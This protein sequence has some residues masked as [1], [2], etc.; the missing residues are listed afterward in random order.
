MSDNITLKKL[1]SLIKIQR[2]FRFLKNDIDSK[3]KKI[4]FYKLVLESMINNLIYCNNLKIFQDI[5]S[6]Y[7]AILGELKEI[8]DALDTFPEFL[9]IKY[10]NTEGLSNISLRLIKCELLILKYLNHIAPENLSYILQ[11]IFNENWFN[12]FE[13][14]DLEKIFFISK[15]FIPICLWDSEVHKQEINLNIKNTEPLKKNTMVTKELIETLLGIKKPDNDEKTDVNINSNQ[16]SNIH[17]NIS[18]FLKSIS[19]IIE[20]SPKNSIKK[21]NNHFTL[22]DCNNLLESNKIIIT[23]NPHSNSLI[24]DKY[25]S[26]VYIRIKDRILVLQGIF[27][28]DLLNMSSSIKFVKDKINQ[29]KSVFNYDILT[30]PKIFKD[31]Y[32]STLSLRDIIVLSPS[33]L[34]NDV[35]K[36][37]NDFKMIQD[38]PLITLINEFLLASKYRKIDILTLL[39]M[40]SNDDK[41]VAYILFDIFKSKDKKDFAHEIYQSLHY[42]IR[43]LLDTSKIIVEKEEAKLSKLIDSD[44]PYERR[45][46]MMKTNDEIKAKAME[47]LK[48]IKSSFQGDNKAQLW[49]DGLLKIPFETFKENEILLFKDSFI[50]K[51]K[52]SEPDIQLFSDHEIDIY[53]TDLKTNNSN[54]SLITEWEK[55][56]VDKKNYLINVRKVLDNT[57]F[58]HK[59]AK[60]Q[61]ERI[62][63]QWIN[64][65]SKGAVLGLQG[66]PGTG[67]T[68]LAKNGLSKCLMDKD[69]KSRPFAFLPIG[70]SVNGSTLVG[71]NFTYVGS[72]WGRIVDVLMCAGCM[73]P[74]I[75][76]DEI[77]K[78]SHTD[79]GKEIISILTHMT[80]STQNDEFEDKFFAGIKIDLSK[81]LIVFSFNDPNL[82]DPILRDRI[83]IVETH[84]LS[85]PE[86]LTIIKDYM[87]P[88]ICKDVGFN[89]N[90]LIFSD[91]LIKHLIDTYTNEAGVRKIKEKIIEIVRDINLN[92]FYTN[93]FNMPY[94]ISLDYVKKLFES[95][96]KVRIK[97]II[98][99]PSIGIVN[100]LYASSGGGL[101]GITLIQA[102]KF[103]SDKMLELNLTG[104]AGDVMKESVQYALKNAFRLLTQE[105]QDK[106]INDAQNK[107]TFGIHIHCPD[108]ATPKDGPSAGLAF[109]LAIYSVLSGRKIKN[110]ICMTG[111]I[112]LIGNAGIIGGLQAK[113]HGGKKSGCTLALIPE[114]NMDDLEKMRRDGLSPEDDNFKVILVTN[115][116]DILQ[117]ALV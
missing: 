53:I 11:L 112:D 99:E 12:F 96:P 25:G 10:V 26:C 59:E 69:G 100:G 106:I 54:N 50:K 111:E 21:R 76:I 42:S 24:E 31:N 101:G 94:T 52:L 95:H 92:R 49:L 47:K 16:S 41:K 7:M 64:G 93:D 87:L 61:L 45:I 66:P 40:S 113:L 75:F 85:I 91:E 5:N 17:S 2:K 82:I 74:I 14:E 23:K 84:S 4:T 56:K 116:T 81:A 88:E 70:G 33:E 19:D 37:Y 48:S 60:L 36:K 65:D 80:D 51:I 35:K 43:E 27:K 44:I 15:F 38:K 55:Y 78:V 83:T 68:A 62:F 97:K 13:K 3:N 117:H 107:K 86:K 30:V 1:S 108:G 57:V 29:H 105:E 18:T 77:D 89:N 104:Q 6:S 28:D 98:S 32:F 103:P 90:E 46:N 63:A 114:D 72:T 39:L 67:K 8:K 102:I 34:S 110:D 73:N 79:H 22:F 109:T 115:I 20:T 58:G 9:T 71:H